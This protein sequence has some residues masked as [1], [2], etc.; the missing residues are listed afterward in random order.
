MRTE[1]EMMQMIL[2]FARNDERIR[3]VGMEGSRVNVSL[4]KDKFQDYDI[5]Y[6]VTDMESFKKD[7]RWLDFFGKR[8]IMQKPEAMAMFPPKLGNWFSY[9]MLFED[10]SRID[11]KNGRFGDLS[12]YAED[13]EA[14]CDT[15]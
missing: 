1:Q 12:G 11:L 7:D 8:I 9:L 5:T 4:P 13:M 6:V 14:L 10:G 15:V 2:S 3:V